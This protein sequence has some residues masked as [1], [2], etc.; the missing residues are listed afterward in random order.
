MMKLQYDENIDEAADVQYELA[1]MTGAIAS[2]RWVGSIVPALALGVVLFLFW[3]SPLQLIAGIIVAAI[4]V[5]FDLFTY[6]KK[7]R[8]RFRRSLIKLRRSEAPVTTEYELDDSG[9]R[10]RQRG[11]ELKADWSTVVGFQCSADRI[12]LVLEPPGIVVI[13]TRAFATE[14]Q[15]QDWIEKI[16]SLISPF[17]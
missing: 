10:I 9:I 17:A 13:P 15:R 3:N 11:Q 8:N 1:E 5:V 4:V 2:R 16:R 7:I 12:K 14:Q 6:K